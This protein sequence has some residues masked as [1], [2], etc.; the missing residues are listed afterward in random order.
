MIPET[1][2][3]ET[4]SHKYLNPNPTH[5]LSV[6]KNTPYS[7]AL[8]VRRNCSDRE[9]DDKLFV[10]HLIPYK[11]YTSYEE[12]AIDKQFIKVAKMKKGSSGI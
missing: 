9:V 10:N 7:V 5:P 3:K 8:R 11:D 4:D 12:E 1:Y 2:S 6:T